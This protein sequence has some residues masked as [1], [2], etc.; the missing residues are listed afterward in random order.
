[1][2]CVF[3]KIIN[4][5]I[6]SEIVYEDENAVGVLDIHP[7]SPGHV[8]ALPKFHSENILDLPDGEIAG[9]FLAV[10]KITGI[11]KKTFNPDGFTIGINHGKASGQAVDHLHIH[12]MP[13][14]HG[15]GGGS[16]H[17]VVNNPTE[18]SLGE[19]ASKIRKNS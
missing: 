18:N 9:V 3:C 12:I 10:K 7:R 19:I 15:D 16:I 13:R 4:K 8:M 2:E 5:E 1:M 14:W 6:G 17:N 11:L